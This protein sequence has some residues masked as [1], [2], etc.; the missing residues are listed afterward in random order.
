MD[1][2]DLRP[3]FPWRHLLIWAVIVPGLLVLVPLLLGAIFG[4]GGDDCGGG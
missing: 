3:A 4:G 1:S 2:H